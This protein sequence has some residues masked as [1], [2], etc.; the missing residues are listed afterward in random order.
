MGMDSKIMEQVLHEEDFVQHVLFDTGRRRT[1]LGI[2]KKR[3]EAEPS[4]DGI[5]HPFFLR[6]RSYHFRR[7]WSYISFQFPFKSS[8]VFPHP[9]FETSKNKMDKF[10][11]LGIHTR[12]R[13]MKY[14]SYRDR[15]C[16]LLSSCPAGKDL[17][18]W[19]D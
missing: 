9:F 16:N 2:V 6:Q 12:K 13:I 15:I 7:N 11:F 14:M 3:G 18:L 8:Y 19:K 1:R 17:P 4:Q 10:L 5:D